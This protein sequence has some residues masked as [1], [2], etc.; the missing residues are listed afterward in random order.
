MKI[1]IIVIFSI[2]F[3]VSLFSVSFGQDDDVKARRDALRRCRSLLKETIK[4]IDAGDYSAALSHIDSVLICDSGNADAYFHKART[5]VRT[6]DTASAVLTLEVG[7]AK[8]PLSSRN[9]L[10]LARLKIGQNAADK[11]SAQCDQVLAIKPNLAEALYIKGLAL[12]AQN[13]TT[14]AVEYFEKAL[15]SQYSGKK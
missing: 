2:C 12:A 13:D 10:L 3:I 5:F 6:G 14:G 8:A 9:R 7:V 4:N 15:D 11:A 1:R